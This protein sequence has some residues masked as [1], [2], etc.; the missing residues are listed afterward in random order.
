MPMNPSMGKIPQSLE[1]SG[2]SQTRQRGDCSSGWKNT[3]SHALPSGE[4]IPATGRIEIWTVLNRTWVE[5]TRMAAT[6][7]AHRAL[8]ALSV[9]LIGG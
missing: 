2:R 5:L 3:D 9:S 8:R 1:G 7:K 6:K 4:I